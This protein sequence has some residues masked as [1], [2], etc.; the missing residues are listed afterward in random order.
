MSSPRQ[1][2][3]GC[4]HVMA[5]FDQHSY[6]THCHEKNK[7]QDPCVENKD[8]TNCKFCLALTAEQLALISTPSYKL[9]KEKREARKAESATPTQE[10]SEL[11]DPS[12]VSVIGVVGQ[13]EPVKSPSSSSVPPEKKVKKDKLS[14]KTKKSSESSSTNTKIVELNQKW[15]DHFNQLEALFLSRTLQPTFSS[16]VKVTPHSSPRDSAIF[17]PTECTGKDSSALLHQ[18]ASQP[19]SDTQTSSERTGKGSSVGKQQSTSQ[20]RSDQHRPDSSSLSPKHTGKGFSAT[21]HQ[22]ASQ[23]TTD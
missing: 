8:T 22:P 3:G 20:L 18:S 5:N 7:E 9:K 4:S 15:S 14:S 17:Q 12:S 16:E 13:K 19:E 2:S 6:C 23:L 10:Y 1:R 11:V 21:L